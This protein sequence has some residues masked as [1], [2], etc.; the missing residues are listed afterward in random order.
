MA[1]SA[2]SAEM[3]TISKTLNPTPDPH[4][5]YLDP[6]ITITLFEIGS[7][8]PSSWGSLPSLKNSSHQVTEKQTAQKFNNLLKEIKD[9][10]KN[11]AGFEEKIT[12]AKE[13]FEETNIPED[14]SAHK[15]NI[16]GLDK[17]NEMLSTNLPVSLAPEKEENERKQEMILETNIP[18]DVS[19]H[20]E[21]I[22]GLD[23]INE[24][25]STNL[26]V[27]LA[28]EKEDNEKKQE[29]IMENQNS[30]NTV[31][32]FARDLVNRL[33]E[34]KVLNETQQSQEKA[35][36]RLNVQEETMKIRNNM[37][38]LLQEAEHWS[39][40][41]TELSKLIKSYQKSQ[42]DISE[43]LGNNGVDFQTQPNN[44]VSAKHELEEQVKKL[45]H[46]TYSLQ[47]MAALLENECQILQ[48]RVEILKELHYQKQGTL[49]EK[50]I[51]INYKQD[52]KNQK[53]SEAK[54]IE[55]YKQNKQEMKGTFRKKDRSC[56]S[57]DVCLNKKACNTQFNIHVARK[58]LRR[59]MRSASSL[60]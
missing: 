55:M 17:I 39:K 7:L 54:K 53:P 59:K 3:P 13:L 30:E 5:E 42:K 10:L 1:S 23:K 6:R 46:D 37:E 57:L 28:P 58:A 34:R 56:R 22:R 8:S 52:K 2:K 19:A 51:Q 20:K 18:E 41:H 36:N 45:S 48:Q 33:E 32:V 4:Q 26:P 47:L 49:Q 12:E 43:T 44:E 29:M 11:M 16:R 24:M 35:K 38:Q 27:S 25:L 40:Q 15:E 21:N 50:P 31:Q 9:I 60:R 14:V